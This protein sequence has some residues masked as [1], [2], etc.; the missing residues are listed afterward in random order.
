MIPWQYKSLSSHS[1]GQNPLAASYNTQLLPSVSKTQSGPATLTLARFTSTTGAAK[2]LLEHAKHALT[3]RLTSPLFCAG[4]LFHKIAPW[5]APL[6]HSASTYMSPP[7]RGLPK[8]LQLEQAYTS[9][10]SLCPLIL[11]CLCL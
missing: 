5:F 8:P 10:L 11:L 9:P 2:L 1:S 7:Q 4:M 3:I 6:P